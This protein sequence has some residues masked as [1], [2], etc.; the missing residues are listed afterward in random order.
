MKT[1]SVNDIASYEAYGLVC[2]KLLPPELAGAA[3]FG[4][5]RA[6]VQASGASVMHNHHEFEMFYILSGEGTI[7][8]D[9]QVSPL[10]A[11]D[12]VHIPGFSDHTLYNTST[13]KTL[14]FITLW[15]EDLKNLKQNSL[16]NT[17]T[18]SILITATPPTPNGDLHL[19]HLSG[20][21]L[22]ADILTRFNTLQGNRAHS[23][24]GSDPNQSYLM[25]KARQT[26]QTPQQIAATNT[27]RIVE[28]LCKANVQPD[29]FYDPSQIPHYDTTVQNFFKTLFEGGKLIEKLSPSLHDHDS[30]EYLF[31]GMVCGNC[32]HCGVGSDG[33][34]CEQCG[35]PNQVV[36]LHSPRQKSCENAIKNGETRRLYLP[37]S[38]YQEA[39]KEFHRQVTMPTHLRALCEK[40]LAE[41]L[42][43]I[44]LSHP[45]DWGVKHTINGYQDQVVYVWAEMAVGY[46]LGANCSANDDHRFFATWNTY[47]TIVQCFGFD[48][49]YFHA[50][51]MPA[52]WMAYSDL[53][54]QQIKL[55]DTFVTNEFLTLEDSKFS[56]S[57]NHLIWA[58]DLI[59]E[60]DSDS[61]RI[62]L[63]KCRPEHRQQSFRK[64]DFL[65]F[66]LQTLSSWEAWLDG[67]WQTLARSFDYLVPDPGAWSVEHKAVYSRAQDLLKGCT[68]SYQAQQ[69][70]PST[71]VGNVEELFKLGINLQALE[72]H[73]QSTDSLYDQLRTNLALQ[74]ALAKLI[75][76][77]L[78][79]IAPEF[80]QR[81]LRELGEPEQQTWPEQIDFI[82]AGRVLKNRDGR[83]FSYSGN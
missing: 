54:K 29:S 6:I 69:F 82:E 77:V 81:L 9:G 31:Q 72:T 41:P 24:T 80:C 42:P 25:L 60:T 47:N 44:C 68:A 3:P 13:T 34:A 15:W 67:L 53:T 22:A 4:A 50:I 78:S 74:L 16:S 37:L 75:A 35:L 10:Q 2:Q 12:T 52:L 5:L 43:D 63:N 57:R 65:V 21:Y 32:P 20:P 55:P 46:A 18:E 64:T 51:L 39:L 71:V 30:G 40:M 83:Y 45:F 66:Q 33:N 56:T 73:M 26:G 1:L 70:S 76:T 28:T 19:G 38:Q 48:N 14:E 27:Q 79:P 61:V 11:G 49:S 17:A 59:D 8:I 7:E 62:F 58:R 36:D 23:L